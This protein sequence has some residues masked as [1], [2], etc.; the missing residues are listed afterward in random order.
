MSYLL[1]E[2]RNHTV[3][4]MIIL[5]LIT[6]LFNLIETLELSYRVG[7]PD[8]QVAQD[9][10]L[11]GQ[12]IREEHCILE[13]KDGTEHNCRF[14]LFWLFYQYCISIVVNC[15]TGVVTF[16]ACPDALC[17]VNGRRVSEPIELQSGY[18]L[19]L[20]R[21]HV[22]RFNNPLHGMHTPQSNFSLTLILIKINKFHVI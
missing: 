20:G 22:F 9:I 13:N 19:V 1:F 7:L 14:M 15:L 21:H 8:A 18:R 17:Y 6:F 16:A 11:S 5:I 4:P 10:K 12:Q 3:C 2:T